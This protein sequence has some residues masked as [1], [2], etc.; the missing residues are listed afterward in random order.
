MQFDFH[1]TN[2]E[3]Q[4]T[5]NI[6]RC[7]SAKKVQRSA[8]V[9]VDQVILDP[10]FVGR[11][12]SIGDLP[13]LGLPEISDPSREDEKWWEQT[14]DTDDDNEGF[15]QED[16]A[17][18]KSGAAAL[19]QIE[20]DEMF[21]QENAI[22]GELDDWQLTV[23]KEGI[24]AF[25]NPDIRLSPGAYFRQFSAPFTREDMIQEYVSCALNLCLFTYGLWKCPF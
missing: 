20:Q 9:L 5:L 1:D 21:D 7:A 17:Q 19:E 6:D 24:Y 11:N 23:E 8:D 15:V 13:A 16:E 10:D 4:N 22:E 3:N 18:F 14:P 25:V 2:D 12:V